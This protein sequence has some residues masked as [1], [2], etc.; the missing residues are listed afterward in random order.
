[1]SYNVL[2]IPEDFTK[3]EHILLPLVRRVLADSGKPNAA[4]LVCR[5]PNFQGISGAFDH[6]RIR[7]EVVLRYP[8][9]NL[10][11]LIVDRDGRHGRSE[12][13]TGNVS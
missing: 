9:V 8:M 5:D 13:M 10:F 6:N 12:I 4:V 3:D 11:I 2:V 7:E 1:M